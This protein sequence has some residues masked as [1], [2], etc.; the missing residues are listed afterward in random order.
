MQNIKQRVGKL[1]QVKLKNKT[2]LRFFSMIFVV[3]PSSFFI[4]GWGPAVAELLK[5]TIGVLIQY[6]KKT[7]LT[8]FSETNKTTKPDKI[9]QY[10][11]KI[12]N[13]ESENYLKSS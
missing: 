3:H 7:A 2:F 4:P 11:C 6:D 13:R 1:S 9:N 5:K 10:K 8:Q 12:S